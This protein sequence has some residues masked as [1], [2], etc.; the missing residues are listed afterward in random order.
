MFFCGVRTA[1]KNLWPWLIGTTPNGWGVFG[2]YWLDSVSGM[3]PVQMRLLA[4]PDWFI[5]ALLLVPFD[6]AIA[7]ATEIMVEQ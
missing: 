6:P 5:I 4:I 7:V 3:P 2:F 1:G